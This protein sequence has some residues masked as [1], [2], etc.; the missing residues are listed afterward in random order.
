MNELDTLRAKYPHL[1]FALYAYEPGGPVTL[2]CITAEGKS[3]QFRGATAA[4]AMAEGFADDL[5][6]A[7]AHPSAPKPSA[8]PTPSVFD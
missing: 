1:G 7:E 6:A 5:P 2:E 8:N 4:A 3:F